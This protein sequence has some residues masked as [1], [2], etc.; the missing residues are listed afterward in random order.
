MILKGK[1]V[2]KYR[3]HE[4]VLNGG[5]AYYMMPGHTTITEAGTEWL[6]FSPTRELKKTDKVVQRNL[7]AM[8]RV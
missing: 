8:N 4:E 5:D 7:R 2:V 3:D 1:K 6:E